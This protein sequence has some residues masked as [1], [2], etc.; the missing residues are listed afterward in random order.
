MR[1]IDLEPVGAGHGRA[2]EQGVD[3]GP[4]VVGLGHLDP[5]F[6]EMRKLLRLAALHVDREAPRREAV[7]LIR[8]QE[9]EIARAE[10]GDELVQHLRIVQGIM[11]A[12]A[13]KAEIDRQR[14]LDL[15]AAVIEQLPL[16]GH[17]GRNPVADDVH[18]HRALVE[19]AEMEELQPERTAAAAEQ[20]LV[21]A[22]ADVA[23][24]V[25]AEPVQR[26]GQLRD[27]CLERDACELAGPAHHIL[28]AEG[29]GCRHA[30]LLLRPALLVESGQ[31][32]GCE[33]A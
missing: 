11:E 9:A 29:I 33:Q 4:L 5:E 23:V 26:L 28:V 6:A 13:C 14:P 30:V 25:E 24:I 2:V 1:R 12:K 15:V 18:R 31:R 20:G 32:G 21:G 19:E 22:K 17:R 8:T 7:F 27:R 10:E 16:I 3:D